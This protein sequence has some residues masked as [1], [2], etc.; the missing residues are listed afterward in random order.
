M[1]VDSLQRLGH[2]GDKLMSGIE[3][4]EKVDVLY[5]HDRIARYRVVIGKTDT[6]SESQMVVDDKQYTVAVSSQG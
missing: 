4:L 6:V 3:M 1:E 5:L 2:F